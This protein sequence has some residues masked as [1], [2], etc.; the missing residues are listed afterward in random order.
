MDELVHRARLAESHL[1]LRRMHVDVH[2]GR[3]ELEEQ[4]IGRMAAAVQDVGVGLA[5]RVGEQLVAHEAAVDEEVLRV[6]AGARVGGQGGE[7]GQAQHPALGRHCARMLQEVVAHQRG[8]PRAGGAGGRR[9]MTRPLWASCR[10]MSGRASATR[11]NMSS[12]CAY[13]VPSVLRNLRR[14]GVL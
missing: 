2:A 9:W 8:D 5:H 14:A 11:R 3:I 1:D 13:S 7:A 6:A 10:P 4:H 12:Q